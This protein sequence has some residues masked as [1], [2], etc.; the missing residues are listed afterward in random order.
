MH[1]NVIEL[2]WAAGFFDGEGCVT[3]VDHAKTQRTRAI[4]IN[5]TQI[6]PEV[7]IR[8]QKAIGNLGSVLG[9]YSAKGRKTPLYTFQI[10]NEKD[11][12]L[13][14][15]LLQ[16]YLSSIKKLQFEEK[17]HNW[18]QRTVKFRRI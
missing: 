3:Y 13:T 17:L 4:R 8:F 1:S 9:P 15:S 10:T 12:K 11:V 16:P 5:I 14:F 18:S 2:A 7:L 6:H